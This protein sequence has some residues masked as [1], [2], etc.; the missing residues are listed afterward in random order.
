MQTDNHPMLW[1]L[2]IESLVPI[3]P[4]IGDE[5]HRWMPFRIVDTF[6]G[7][8][9]SMGGSD[10]P[11]GPWGS[12]AYFAVFVVLVLLIGFGVVRRRDA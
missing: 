8:V 12:L 7:S 4:N 3:I 2:L 6:L 11:F 10:V 9:H 5:L 1:P